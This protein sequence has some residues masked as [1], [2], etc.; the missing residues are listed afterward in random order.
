MSKH[1]AAQRVHR[2]EMLCYVCG[3]EIPKSEWPVP[4]N[5]DA[6]LL[7]QHC[8]CKLEQRPCIKCLCGSYTFFEDENLF[9]RVL[10]HIH[11]SCNMIRI[12]VPTLKELYVVPVCPGCIAKGEILH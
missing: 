11:E 9:R 8:R 5:A 7:C 12:R 2:I 1:E 3:T 4:L 6:E 10:D